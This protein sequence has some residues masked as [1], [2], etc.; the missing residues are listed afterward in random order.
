MYQPYQQQYSVQQ[1]YN[2]QSQQ[3]YTPP[4][5]H[6]EII[7]VS[8]EQEAKDYPVAAGNTQMFI[9]KD[10]S[11]IYIK[12]AY[13]NTPAQLVVYKKSEPEPDVKPDYITSEEFEKRL[14]EFFNS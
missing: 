13:V 12:T 10:D 9:A 8:S 7:Q 5:I 3:Q 2:S 1:P 14:E 4:T 6:A 11:A